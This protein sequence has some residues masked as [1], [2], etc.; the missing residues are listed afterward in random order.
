MAPPSTRDHSRIFA[1]RLVLVFAG[2]SALWILGSDWLLSRL[3]NDAQQLARISL[4]K[5]WF[6]VA[7]ASAGLWVA[8][9]WGRA[10]TAPATEDSL[11]QGPRRSR[12]LW[13]AGTAL[14]A[15][16]ALWGVVMLWHGQQVRT[17]NGQR[18]A[19]V[20]GLMVRQLEGWVQEQA[21]LANALAQDAQLG[22]HLRS[23]LAA[24]EGS[25]A[26]LALQQHLSELR[27]R[28]GHASYALLDDRGHRLMGDGAVG[29]GPA[30]G[31][32]EPI[33]GNASLSLEMR[34]DLTASAY[35]VRW[36][37]SLSDQGSDAR[38]QLWLDRP[39]DPA[40][41]ALWRQW[42]GADPGTESLLVRRDGASVRGLSAGGGR[43]RPLDSPRLLAARVLR[44]ETPFGQPLQ[45]EDF[46]DQPV[47]GVMRPVAGTP[48]FLVTKRALPA[49]EADTWREAAGALVATALGV[50]TYLSLGLLGQARQQVR[51]ARQTSLAQ[52]E[53]LRMAALIRAIAEGSGDAIFAKDEQ[54]R[55]LLFNQAAERITGQPATRMIGRDDR[56]LFPPE[57][58]EQ[59][60]Q[61]DLAVMTGGQT[62]SFEETLQTVAGER[63]FLATKGPLRDADGALVGM[64]GISRDV[65]ELKRAE[66]AL[67][68][69]SEHLRMTVAG[70]DLG[71]W[72]W[73]VTT[74]QV[75]FN[76][77]W[78]EMLGYRLDELAPHIETWQRLVHPDDWPVIN[79]SLEPHLAGLSPAYR[80]EHRLRHRDGHWI[81]VLDSGS[82]MERDA[83]GRALR[84]AGVHLDITA[85]RRLLQEL[86]EHRQLLESRVAERTAELAEARARAEAASRAKSTFLANMS[87]EIRT[88]MNAIIGLGRLV[89]DQG[90]TPQQAARLAGIDDAAR[91]LLNLLNDILDLSKIEAGHLVLAPVTFRLGDLLF[92]ACKLTQTEADAK[93]LRL[94]LDSD[95]A[96]DEHLWIGDV[97]RLR[98]ALINYLG[99]AV[100][101][102][103]R[104]G[105]TVQV[106]ALQAEAGR[107]LLQFMVSDTGIGIEPAHQAHLFEAFEQADT[108]TTRRFGGTG[109]G[110]AITRRLARM[111][112]GEVGLAS[113]PGQGSRF[114]F[115]AWLAHGPAAAAG[116]VADAGTAVPLEPAL[117]R[118][119][120]RQQPARVLLV[121]DNEVN[122]QVLE[123]LLHQAGLQVDSAEDGQ[124]A[125]G[126]LD[127]PAPDLVLMDVQMPRLDGLAATRA[128]RRRPALAELPVLALTANAFSE[129]RLACLD[130]GM[131]DFISK[132]VDPDLLYALLLRWLSSA[133]DGQAPSPGHSG[134]DPMP[135]A[136]AP[137]AAA[138]QAVAPP[139]E[140][141][142]A[143]PQALADA[144]AELRQALQAGRWDA[145]AL[146]RR[147]GPGLQAAHGEPVALALTL[148]ARFDYAAALGQLDRLR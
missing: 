123:E 60:R 64:F 56:E 3:V 96:L 108:S 34:P 75:T 45:A 65:T 76:E 71:L 73:Q 14:L 140:L 111:M 131:N 66:Q 107:S 55:Y 24:A 114:W 23:G 33:A 47:L 46:R 135:P 136:G 69:S 81:W 63:V 90:A 102:T 142:E 61:N 9:Q 120:R 119:R 89:R 113:Q 130:A 18:L 97:T 138:A 137:V 30:P 143:S 10:P 54:G 82:V 74:G 116:A 39:A 32:L 118:L 70:A 106:R 27:H 50:F 15:L 26:R 28:Y 145:Q 43:P 99:N 79:A 13:R 86:E 125:L 31:T 141:A 4:L 121:E 40:V 48:W 8:L 117:V 38:I 128:L 37:V 78:A 92:E 103:A 95:P 109:L 133:P 148:V 42:P 88:P 19:Q 124:A 127:G 7:V 147:W 87:H 85:Q 11:L 17:H 49:I 67:R 94:Q 139:P 144:L 20:N 134:T 110:L 105:V 93:G 129:D 44:G 5:G 72:D 77:R 2:L 126:A 115:T 22:P 1:A 112:G 122:R 52:R 29:L 84:A 100:K 51:A 132:P 25:P 36:Q 101:F 80:C 146:A 91:H 53:Q 59:V 98:Q 104:G 58:A 57:Q 21:R 35:Q 12:L 62:R 41:L 6:Y 83:Q 16:A 68:E